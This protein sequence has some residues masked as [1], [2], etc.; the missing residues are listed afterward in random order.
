MKPELLD[1][2][3][4]V[5][6]RALIEK[7]ENWGQGRNFMRGPY[8]SD[9]ENADTFCARG[10][11]LKVYGFGFSSDLK[12]KRSFELLREAVGV[13]PVWYNDSNTHEKVLGMFDRA[14]EKAK[15]LAG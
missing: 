3:M 15:A 8:Q 2:E 14:I 13:N 9:M 4:L 1:Y 12:G 11:L 10:A 6:A 5:K 7:P